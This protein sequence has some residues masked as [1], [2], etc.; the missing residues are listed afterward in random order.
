MDGEVEKAVATLFEHCSLPPFRV[1]GFRLLAEGD[2]FITSDGYFCVRLVEGSSWPGSPLEFNEERASHKGRILWFRAG[3]AIENQARCLITILHRGVGLPTP[4]RFLPRD[5]TPSARWGIE[6]ES[7]LELRAGLWISAGLRRGVE[8]STQFRVMTIAAPRRLDIHVELGPVSLGIEVDGR[9]HNRRYDSDRKRDA[10]ILREQKVGTIIRLPEQ[11]V[12]QRLPEIWSVLSQQA[13][14]IFGDH[15]EIAE[16]SFGAPAALRRQG[17]IVLT[18]APAASCEDDIVACVHD[19]STLRRELDFVRTRHSN[20]VREWVGLWPI[21][22]P[23]YEVD[24]AEA[25]LSA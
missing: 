5:A 6:V 3:D 12:R 2:G 21:R 15:P 17:A 10:L 20:E 7:R 22:D 9:L 8:F 19:E 11:A 18:G 13:P 24:L 4:T 25:A 23:S 1:F 14:S 16:G